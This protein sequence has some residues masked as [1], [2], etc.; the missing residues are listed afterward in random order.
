VQSIGRSWSEFEPAAQFRNLV[1]SADFS[2]AEAAFCLSA[3]MRCA[4]ADA[5]GIEPSPSSDL[6]EQLARLD[7]LAAAVET[8]TSH[9]VA[10]HLF[11]SGLFRGNVARYHD[12]DNSALDVVLDRGLGIPITLSVLM[13]EV[14]ARVG[15]PLC[16]VGLPGHFVVGEIDGVARIPT[17][18]FDPF[19]GGT[20]LDAED[21]RD[22]VN[23]LAGRPVA[24]PPECWY[25]ASSVAVIER[26]L[27]N[28][29]AIWTAAV[30][31]GDPSAL[32]VVRAV[33]WLRSCLAT[34]GESERAEWSRLVAPF[35]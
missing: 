28:L 18:F 26:M 1:A 31:S 11:G 13:I 4:R 3:V 33:M 15:V 22:L 5:H 12:P 24:I 32:L 7:E 21:C 25:P 10:R 9:G 27:N 34:I 35:N 17:R 19:H 29:K 6:V 30:G 20:V 8:P 14:A 2:L 16:G 23:R